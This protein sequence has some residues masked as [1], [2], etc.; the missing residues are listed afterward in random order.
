MSSPETAG[1][2]DV[3]CRARAGAA[4]VH[5][6][7]V[8]GTGMSALGHLLLDLGCR[9]SGSDP[10]RGV[11]V[12]ALAARGM[13]FH[14]GHDAAWVRGAD[15]VVYSAAIRPENPE[16]QAA[17]Q[18]GIPVLKRAQAL[19]GLTEPR[20]TL[21]VAGTHGKTSSALMLAHVLRSCGVDCGYYIGAETPLLGVNGAWGSA[22]YIVIE[23]DESDGTL[24]LYRPHGVLILNI[25]AEHLDHYRGMDEIVEA[26]SGLARRTAG[27]GLACADQAQAASLAG[28]PGMESYGFAGRWT[29]EN[30]AAG[31]GET[32]Y[33]F[34]G[35]GVD[36]PV[37]LPVPG[38]HQAS[39]SC[40]VLACALK[41]GVDAG[42]AAAALRSFLPAG[43]R[44]EVR[45]K[46]DEFLVVD[47]YAHHPTEIRAT[48]EA[49]ASAGR[50]RILAGFQPHRFSRTLSLRREFATCFDGADALFVADVYPASE[51]PLPQVDAAMVAGDIEAAKSEG[52]RL[53]S[54]AA[55]PTLKDLKSA[56]CQEMQAGDCLLFLGA[57]DITSTAREIAAE[58]ELYEE[59]RGLC[60]EG[61]IL[62]PYE[63]MRRHTSLRVGGPAQ[64]WFEPAGEESLARVLRRSRELGLDITVVGRGTN[65]LVKDHGIRGLCVH[66]GRPAFAAVRVEGG[67]IHAGCGARLKQIV[68]EA[69]KAGLGGLEFMEGIPGNLGG[70][71]RM[72]A[73]AMQGS[74]FQAVES[75]RVMDFSGEIRE[76]H[77]EEMEVRYRCVPLLQN[78]VALGAVLKAAPKPVEEIDGVLKTYSQKRWSSQPAAPTAG[79]TFKNDA[80]IPAGKLIDE[81]GLKDTRVGGARISEVHANFI[82][83]DGQA[84]A[85]DVLG[86][87]D[88]VR[89]RAKKERGIDLEPEVIVLGE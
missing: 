30:F 8:A 57:G 70:A 20:K 89:A 53:Q 36:V 39:N 18:A 80:S 22:E 5:L 15:L 33:R 11:L 23:A 75:V 60:G 27:F 24:E 25:E 73:G 65:L 51:K 52:R 69:R 41:L 7:G 85:A 9:V 67:R 10:C 12:D 3:L 19:A 61:D 49:A 54:A 83:N 82:V 31:A 44:F 81:L 45:F 37:V 29:L 76:C 47:D 26:F 32:S 35:P 42:R 43:R 13:A 14:K 71:L 46:S 78:A 63:P 62:R 86:L 87:M 17:E 6:V 38:R 79:C 1:I 34:K 88:I 16:R 50:K 56:L 55:T 59:L 66:L 84:T 4:S 48:L 68:A 40:G 58:L 64:L 77:A 21:I 72:N 28:L 2:A 74:T